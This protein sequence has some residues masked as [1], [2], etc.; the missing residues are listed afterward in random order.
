[1]CLQK[2]TH[3]PCAGDTNDVMG[4]A[5]ETYSVCVISGKRAKKKQRQHNVT[6]NYIPQLKL[7][8][9]LLVP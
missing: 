3:I 4:P 5:P 9:T 2:A 7:T 1:M 6:I 8:S